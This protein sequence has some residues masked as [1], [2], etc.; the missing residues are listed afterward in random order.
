MI[1]GRH[2]TVII[3]ALNEENAISR[4]IGDLPE[5][6]DRVIVVDNGSVD[7]TAI[8][9]RQAGATVVTEHKKGYGSAC[10]A[11]IHE[12]GDTDILAFID[13]DYSD[14][15]E[16]LWT[17]LEP[18]ANDHCDL[19]IGCRRQDPDA[20]PALPRHQKWGNRLACCVIHLIHGFKYEDLGPMRCLTRDTL[21]KLQM[22]DS[23]FGWTV[24]MQIKASRAG[25]RILQ[26]PVRYRLRIGESKISGTFTGAVMAAYKIAYWTVKLA[27]TPKSLSLR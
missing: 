19:A 18:L 9:A 16:D 3:P 27:F 14:Y 25:A 21:E 5:V 22:Q 10:I 2:I 6:V 23:D 13:G 20:P 1:N 11:G 26:V 15:P 12:S 24:E 4:V 17:I 8:R 7:D